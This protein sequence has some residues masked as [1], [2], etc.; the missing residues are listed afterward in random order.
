MTQEEPGHDQWLR[1]AQQVKARRL[2]LGLSQRQ[3]AGLADISHTTW[4]HLEKH[5]Q[6]ISDATKVG[7]AKAL[8]WRPGAIDLL[9]AGFGGESL[10]AELPADLNEWGDFSLRIA[11]LSPDVRRIIKGIVEAEES[12]IGQPGAGD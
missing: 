3:A 8:R 5:H 12:R 7:M 4:T 1:V 2:D 9:L 10:L 6:P 11:A